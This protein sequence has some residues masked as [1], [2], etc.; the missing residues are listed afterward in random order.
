M[1][2][3]ERID[4]IQLI[5]TESVGALTF[6]R[7]LQKYGSATEVLKVLSKNKKIMSRKDAAYELEKAQK[8][9]VKILCAT[10]DEYPQALACLHDAPPVLYVKGRTDILNH[11]FI[12]SIVGSRNASVNGRR[13]A[14][15]IAFDL[16]QN[17][18]IVVSGMARGIDAAAHK[19]AMYAKNKRAPTI[20]V[21]GCGADV[22]YP[23][24]NAE[25]YAQICDQGAIVSEF[26]LGTE[27]QSMYFPRRNR[28]VSGL[29]AGVLVV[30]ASLN[31][32]S[33]ITAKLALEQGKDVFAVPCSPVENRGK[34]CNKLIREGAYL[35]ES[36]EDILDVLHFSLNQKIKFNEN[37]LFTAPLDKGEKSADI[38]MQ[39]FLAP[40]NL[41]LIDLIG[42]EGIE[43]NE[44]IRQSNQPTSEVL[45]RLTELELE[46]LITRAGSVI[47]PTVKK[48]R[49]KQ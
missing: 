20:A 28:L 8:L 23:L 14:S 19:G 2:E 4:W 25:L 31:S 32:G 39:N 49:K 27:P 26:R 43:T 12:F 21:L 38:P 1:T 15:R 6:Q 45:M 47:L 5:N 3:E 46:G 10:D 9:G 48:N 42:T 16:T 18:I 17:E 34:G 24:E 33:L 30:E 41:T 29:S 40:Q 13:I 35:A 36:A 22:I 11:P 37:N 7:Y 44:L